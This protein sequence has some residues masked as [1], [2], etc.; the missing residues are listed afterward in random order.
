MSQFVRFGDYYVNAANVLYV[1]GESNER[2]CLVFFTP[3]EKGLPVS[4]AA[5]EVV[6]ILSNPPR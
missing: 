1:Q 5:S 3:I 2:N 6:R 4:M